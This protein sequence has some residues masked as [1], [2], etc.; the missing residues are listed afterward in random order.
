MVN[1]SAP[2]PMVASQ[3]DLVAHLAEA[4]VDDGGQRHHVAAEPVGVGLAQVAE[5][6][7][8]V[9]VV[10][11]LADAVGVALVDVDERLHVGEQVG[12]QEAEL[13]GGLEAG[14]GHLPEPDRPL[15]PPERQVVGVL[16]VVAERRLGVRDDRVG[17]VDED[18][19]ALAQHAGVGGG[20]QLDQHLR[21]PVP[22]RS[23]EVGR[24]RIGALAVVL[25]GV[26][27]E[28]LERV[29]GALALAELVL[30]VGAPPAG[31]VGALVAGAGHVEHAQ[32]EG[33]AR[34]AHQLRVLRELDERE[35]RRDVLLH[36]DVA[37]PLEE[38]EARPLVDPVEDRWL[39]AL[40]VVG[41]GEAGHGEGAIGHALAGEVL[42]DQADDDVVLGP[43]PLVVEAVGRQRVVPLVPVVGH[44]LLDR[45]DHLRVERAHV[46]LAVGQAHHPVQ[47]HQ[48]EVARVAPLVDV[49]PHV[50]QRVDRDRGGVPAEGVVAVGGDQVGADRHRAA[51][52]EGSGG[53]GE[54]RGGALL[55]GGLVDQPGGAGRGEGVVERRGGAVAR[56]AATAVRAAAAAVARARAERGRAGQAHRADQEPSSI[57]VHPEVLP[58]TAWRG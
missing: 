43:E 39:G 48:L 18:A 4:V 38:A 6:H 55:E 51:W 11:E 10:D 27:E 34:G 29:E 46:G 7:G 14:R 56:P 42:V 32:V 15:R 58:S 40:L 41:P 21:E 37:V 52:I 31:G 16:E 2:G 9:V 50:L 5:V 49:V 53:A 8:V 24:T 54:V 25:V 12:L 17:A 36:V 28:Q 19:V 22:G 47:V 13:V 20:G 57:H 44:P 1:T 26:V 30:G 3:V 45:L 35:Q 33:H 23:G